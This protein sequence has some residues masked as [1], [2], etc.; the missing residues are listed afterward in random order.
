MPA[1]E[2]KKKKVDKGVQKGRIWGLDI[3]F[4]PDL[5]PG[6]GTASS[7]SLINSSQAARPV[8]PC[9]LVRAMDIHESMVPDVTG[10][11]CGPLK[12]F[13]TVAQETSDSASGL[14]HGDLLRVKTTPPGNT[15]TGLVLFVALW[16]FKNDLYTVLYSF[17]EIVL[18]VCEDHNS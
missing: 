9:S 8:A 18:V 13:K 14:Q 11:R 10:T 17:I 2:K 12:R 1:P 4:C 5:N 3:H 7:F 16:T 6:P 15:K